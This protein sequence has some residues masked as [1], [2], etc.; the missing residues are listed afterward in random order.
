MGDDVDTLFVAA[1]LD[2]GD[3][4][5]IELKLGLVLFLEQMTDLV[6]PGEENRDHW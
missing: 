5:E 3:R 2:E 1:G 4:V 6:K